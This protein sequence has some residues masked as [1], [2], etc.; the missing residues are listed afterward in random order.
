M[1]CPFWVPKWSLHK[2]KGHLSLRHPHM[3]TETIL[4]YIPKPFSSSLLMRPYI[5]ELKKKL[6]Q[7]ERA[8][9][10]SKGIAIVKVLPCGKKTVSYAQG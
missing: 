6:T 9:L 4:K 5:D 2:E 8:K 10:S 3:V 7:F 1:R